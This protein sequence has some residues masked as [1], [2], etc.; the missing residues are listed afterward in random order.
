MWPLLK[1]LQREL[2]PSL[3]DGASF[4][5]LQKTV[6]KSHGGADVQG[7]LQALIVARDQVV[8][9]VPARIRLVLSE[10]NILK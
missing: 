3:Y 1:Q 2:D 9:Q 6:V 7:F 10:E 5:G 8:Q 4:L